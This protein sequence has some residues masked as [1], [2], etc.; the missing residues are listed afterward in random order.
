MFKLLIEDDQGQKTEVNLARDE[1]TLGRA[2]E[3]TV[4]L[5]ERN[6][7]RLHAR[8]VKNGSGWQLEDLSSYNGCFVNGVR[9]NG[10]S[11][12]QHGD[13]LQLGDYRLSVV[14]EAAEGAG[15]EDKD[16]WRRTK[17]LANQPDRLVMLVGPTPGAEF[18]LGDHKVIGRGDDCDIPINHASVSRVHAEIRGLGDG[19]FEIID[20]GS[21]NGVR[22]NGVELERALIDA[23]DNIELG[24]VVM[25]FIPA[26]QIYRPAA[27]ERHQLGT[28]DL[29]SEAAPESEA[30]PHSSAGPTRA[31]KT[32]AIAA[33][34]G[35]ALLLAIVLFRALGPKTSVDAGPRDFAATVL[36]RADQLLKA[37]K[38]EAAH[39]QALKLPPGSNARKS[40]AFRQIEAEWADHLFERAAA[41]ESGEKRAL[42]DRVA[43]A[44]TVDSLRRRRAAQE[45]AA[46]EAEGVD[47]TELPST[48]K[49]S[50]AEEAA[51]ARPEA[52]PPRVQQKPVP[53]PREKPQ[54]APITKKPP[55]K[56]AAT[57]ATLVRENPF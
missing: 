43:R 12:L 9:V 23:R 18:A 20:K 30:A 34:L 51:S 13:L 25:R 19:R 7:S 54:P 49:R 52:E 14:D 5:T 2:E 40:A 15:T 27:E 42:L 45:L 22:L 55:P 1:Y 24:D 17:T 53:P 56:A 31:T 50:E 8:L 47:V 21:A 32:V 39:E 10:Q 44:P 3:N 29:V 36:E 33:G 26:G 48:P 6:I 11:E 35:I 57:N 37:G 41:A 46:L 16:T 28:G 38:V 4:R